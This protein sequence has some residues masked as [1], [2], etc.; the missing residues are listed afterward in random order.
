MAKTKNSEK[1]FNRLIA[2]FA[3]V[4]FGLIVLDLLVTAIQ[5]KQELRSSA[6][7]YYF[8][9]PI[10]HDAG[11]FSTT[12]DYLVAGDTMRATVVRGNINTK[13]TTS[14]SKWI[15]KVGSLN[16]V[17]IAGLHKALTFSAVEDVQNLIKDVP[18]DVDIIEYNMEGGLTPDID[19]SR[20]GGVAASVIIFSK[21]VKDHNP[22]LKVEFAPIQSA[23]AGFERNN[24]LPTILNAID[25]VGIQEQKNY[26]NLVNDV[27]QKVA[28]FK[29]INPKIKIYIQLWLGQQTTAEMVNGFKSIEGLGFD[30]AILGTHG[31]EAGV[32][33]VLKDLRGGQLPIIINPTPRPTATPTPRPA[34][35]P[36]PRLTATPTPRPT[37]T[38]L[39][40]C[41]GN[42]ATVTV[43]K[44]SRNDGKHNV[45]INWT[46]VRYTGGYFI[47]QCTGTD[48]DPDWLIRADETANYYVDTNNGNG[49]RSGT[50]VRYRIVPHT[51][52]CVTLT[53]GTHGIT[54]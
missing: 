42:C 17:N 23:W 2:S 11:F 40:K 36:T 20:P 3:V 31:D 9:K 50:F 38:P 54:L 16:K 19:F 33:S 53:C 43:D 34:A 35:T 4:F 5:K 29:G 47:Y 37:P 39:I 27:K 1:C 24:S 26:P 15:A 52:G 41:P 45:K 7:G 49:Y 14:D 51:A 28:T 21:T 18:E 22:N 30:V 32:L 10:A 46:D 12:K 13:M 8:S 48:C 6:A 44:I 25:M